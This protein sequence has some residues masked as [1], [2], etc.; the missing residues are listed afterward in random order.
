ML[1]ALPLCALN[2]TTSYSVCMLHV[3]VCHI[4][5]A[6]DV[7]ALHVVYCVLPFV[8][9]MGTAVI[10]ACMLYCLILCA[11]GNVAHVLYV[12]F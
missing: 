11:M 1:W 2:T 8:C 10:C 4:F 9:A 5:C 12:M 7:V 3:V 6:L